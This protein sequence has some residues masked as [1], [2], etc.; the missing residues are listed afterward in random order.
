[1]AEKKRDEAA[2]AALQTEFEAIAKMDRVEYPPKPPV[3]DWLKKVAETQDAAGA[4]CLML[5][6]WVE[7]GGPRPPEYEDVLVTI[8]TL[9][10]IKF[11]ASD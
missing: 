5:M 3:S 9:L 11:T 2:T 1:M 10:R 8:Y 7:L 4:L 6:K